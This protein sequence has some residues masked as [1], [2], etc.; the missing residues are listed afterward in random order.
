VADQD[1]WTADP[2]ERAHGRVDV[3]FHRVEAVLCG[4]HFVPFRPKRRDQLLET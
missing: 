3:A 4:H 1:D 2:P